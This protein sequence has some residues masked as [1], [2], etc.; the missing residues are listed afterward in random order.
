MKLISEYHLTTI[1]AK[2]RQKQLLTALKV[3]ALGTMI[4]GMLFINT[5]NRQLSVIEK[6]KPT[7]VLV[8]D[9]KI[10]E[11]KG[12][13][14]PILDN[15]KPV[16]SDTID[17]VDL[18]LK[19]VEEIVLEVI[20]GNWGNEPERMQ[21]LTEAG[22]DYFQIQGYVNQVLINNVP[23]TNLRAI[24]V[25]AREVIQGKWGEGEEKKQRLEKVGFDVHLIESVILQTVAEESL[26]TPKQYTKIN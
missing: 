10:K 24:D 17:M 26:E 9:S 25:I 21:K 22:Y 19:P 8:E 16:Q 7:S 13:T 6:S 23:I 20:R 2:L 4:G 12:N 1:A 18:Y 5:G 14:F 11:K 15:L 3:A